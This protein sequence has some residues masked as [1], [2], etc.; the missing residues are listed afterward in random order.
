MSGFV[1]TLSPVGSL[2]FFLKIYRACGSTLG[3]I[4]SIVSIHLWFLG[5]VYE[6]A[7]SVILMNKQELQKKTSIVKVSLLIGVWSV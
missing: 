6:I 4:M 5:K 7:Y 3:V 2:V 1:R